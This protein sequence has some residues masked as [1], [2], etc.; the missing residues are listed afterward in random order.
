MEATGYRSYVVR[1]WSR[2]RDAEHATRVA[3]EEV[4]SG[5]QVELRGERAAEVSARILAA[6]ASDSGDAESVDQ[7]GDATTEREPMHEEER[8]G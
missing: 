8:R 1:A 7:A 2:G 3:I 5:R 6:L 4:Q